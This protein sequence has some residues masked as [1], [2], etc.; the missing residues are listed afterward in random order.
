MADN[1]PYGIRSGGI[2]PRH[3]PAADDPYGIRSGAIVAKRRATKR[4]DEDDEET[5]LAVATAE[6]LP[7]TPGPKPTPG[8]EERTP[9]PPSLTDEIADS[10]TSFAQG[11]TLNW[12]DELLALTNHKL[13]L[14]GGGSLEEQREM[15]K[16]MMAA[17]TRAYP[18]AHGAG[19]AST[20]LLTSAMLPAGG[21]VVAQGL[22]QGGLQG[23]QSA[24]SSVGDDMPLS[25]VAA[26]TGIGAASGV[27]GG[28]LGS[29]VG[30]LLARTPSQQ[31]EKELAQLAAE[32]RRAG[33][34]VAMPRP[35]APPPQPPVVP[36]GRQ[37]VR[38]YDLGE[39]EA[40]G[41]PRAPQLPPEEVAKAGVRETVALERQAA[42]APSSVKGR[43]GDAILGVAQ[44]APIPGIPSAARATRGLLQGFRA[45]QAEARGA[46]ASQLIPNL[47]AAR[48]VT[49]ATELASELLPPGITGSKAN[50]QDR[51]L[52]RDQTAYADAPAMNYALSATLSTGNTGLSEADEAALTKAVVSGDQAAIN[53][54][55][56]RLRQRYPA[57]ARRVERE[58]RGLNEQE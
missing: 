54:A 53:A 27:A 29:S 55:D 52:A 2:V 12:M 25:T 45:A 1:D 48:R 34:R 6:E 56:F 32:G 21:G 50:A 26:N 37:T 36:P 40:L 9:K 22:L 46:P 23:A 30:K 39:L 19:Q 31:L 33:P 58:L 18:V 24:A 35:E 28:V 15:A 8:R 20:G 41:A 38:N 3:G 14:N 11:S 7:E 10:A 51:E 16:S 13:G 57:Y 4:P 5:T 43:V 49:G 17:K 47:D 42:A 44:Y